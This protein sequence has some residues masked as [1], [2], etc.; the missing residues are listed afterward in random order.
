[1]MVVEN[2]SYFIMKGLEDGKYELEI[3]SEGFE[4]TIIPN[5]RFPRDNDKVMSLSLTRRVARNA[6]QTKSVF[7]KRRMGI[8]FLYTC[9]FLKYIRVLPC[10][11]I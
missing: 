4:T 10:R 7:D 1:M 8:I 6:K 5:F 3:S 11:F 2:E 9:P